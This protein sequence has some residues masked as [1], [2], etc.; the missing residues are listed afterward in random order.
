MKS[1]LLRWPLFGLAAVL[2]CGY[3]LSRGFYVGSAIDVSA[4]EGPDKLIYS[5]SCRYLHLDGVHGTI[6]RETHSREE[7]ESVSCAPLDASP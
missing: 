2:V 5:K 4:R 1:S 7:A 6:G 3:A